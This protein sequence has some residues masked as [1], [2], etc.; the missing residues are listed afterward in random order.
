MFDKFDVVFRLEFFFLL[1]IIKFYMILFSSSR[2]Y[3]RTDG[4]TVRY[5]EVNSDTLLSSCL[6]CAV[7]Q[8]E[9]LAVQRM[10]DPPKNSGSLRSLVFWVHTRP[11]CV[12][13]ALFLLSPF[14]S[15]I[16]EVSSKI[17]LL[18]ILTRN[19]NVNTNVNE[20]TR[21]YIYNKTVRA[22][23][24][25]YHTANTIERDISSKIPLIWVYKDVNSIM[26][27]WKFL[28]ILRIWFLFI[29]FCVIRRN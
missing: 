25:L 27:F 1:L 8:T 17:F 22:S 23:F 16:P 7:K 26:F 13:Y 28:F 3:V 29:N 10:V 14:F 9:I 6:E 18:S 15:P 11:R 24:D 4:R 12:L 20:N 2:R 5:S 19:P 21:V